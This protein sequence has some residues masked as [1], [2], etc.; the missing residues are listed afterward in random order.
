MPSAVNF[1]Q[2]GVILRAAI[3][4]AAR[5]KMAATRA[6]AARPGAATAVPTAVTVPRAAAAAVY[7]PETGFLLVSRG[8]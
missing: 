2:L 8:A 4:A 7:A 5:E 3:Q 1:Q 6:A